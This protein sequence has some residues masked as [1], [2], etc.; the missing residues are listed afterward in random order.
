[1]REG[2]GGLDPGP[3]LYPGQ[4]PLT[5][6]PTEFQ[7]RIVFLKNPELRKGIKDWTRRLL[8][9]RKSYL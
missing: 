4:L 9:Q 8:D 1:M 6:S 3:L 5:S 7:V 2:P